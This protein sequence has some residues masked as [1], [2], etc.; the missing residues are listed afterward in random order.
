MD[1][2]GKENGREPM[3]RD[4]MIQFLNANPLCHLATLEEGQPRVRGMLLYRADSTGLLFHTAEQKDLYRQV[5]ENPHAEAC[6]ISPD[7]HLQV[8]VRGE[9]EI[10]EDLDLKK[11]MVAAR[12]FLQALVFENGYEV[13]KVLRMKNCVATLWTYELNF[14]P[15]VF[16]ELTDPL[17]G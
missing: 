7:G 2:D 3:N 15:K 4:D 17:P 11:E 5:R 12:E 1:R 9:V 16:M 13:L 10:V 14:M 8:R 6:F